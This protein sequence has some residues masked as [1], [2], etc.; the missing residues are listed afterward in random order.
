MLLQFLTNTLESVVSFLVEKHNES[1]IQYDER[2]SE[3]KN[4]IRAKNNFKEQTCFA[5][6]KCVV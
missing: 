6:R 4:L 3:T 1:Y 2:A 5:L